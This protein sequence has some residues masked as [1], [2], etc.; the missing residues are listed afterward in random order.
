MFQAQMKRFFPMPDYDLSDSERVV[1]SI[2]GAILD[3]KYTRL[4][5]ERTDL[6]LWEVLLLDKVQ[7]DIRITHDESKKLKELELVEGRY[8]NLLISAKV[9]KITNQKVKHIRSRGLDRKYYSKMI[10]ELIR[11][12]APIQRGEIDRLLLD[13][14]PENL[15]IKK[16]QDLIHNLISSLRQS[17]QIQNIGSKKY[18]KWVLR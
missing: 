5:M 3:E 11:I 8:P 13:K 4:L 7:K 17:G 14:L 10:L 1:V 2:S 12:H 9:A 16:K 6:D 15:S 18:P